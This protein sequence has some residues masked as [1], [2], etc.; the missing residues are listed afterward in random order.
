VGKRQWKALFN[1]L[2]CD[3]HCPFKETSVAVVTLGTSRPQCRS[4]QGPI[5]GVSVSSQRKGEVDIIC[6]MCECVCTIEKGET[7][8]N[9]DCFH[10]CILPIQISIFRSA[11]AAADPGTAW[12][13]ATPPTLQNREKRCLGTDMIPTY[14]SLCKYN[15]QLKRKWAAPFFMSSGASCR[16]AGKLRRRKNQ[17]FFTVVK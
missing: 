12:G 6:S 10:L 5:Q 13:S 14:V 8:S 16:F 7:K 17:S 11:T 3:Q 1:P 15:F 2:T 4:P 9:T